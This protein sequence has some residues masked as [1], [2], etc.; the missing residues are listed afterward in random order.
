MF[1]RLS[2]FHQA[3]ERDRELGPVSFVASRVRQS[4]RPDPADAL[5]EAMEQGRCLVMLDGLDEVGDPDRQMGLGECLHE[6]IRRYPKNRYILTTRGVGGDDR[7][8]QDRGFTRLEI[9]RWSA[10]EVEQFLRNWSA[11]H[12]GHSPG[13][14]CRECSARSQDL[15]DEIGRLPQVR[16]IAANPLILTILASL[17]HANIGL[18]RKRRVDLYSKVVETFLVTWE[19]KKLGARPGE[20][21]HGLALE[22]REFEWF[23]AALALAMVRKGLTLAP[24]WWVTEL[25]QGYLQS[26]LGFG[27]EEAKQECDRVMRYLTERSGLLV[28]RGPDVFGYSHLTFQEYFASREI[29]QESQAD[30]S[31]DVASRLRDTIYN[32]RWR[33]TVRLVAAQLSPQQADGLLR[34]ILDDPDPIGRFLRRGQ[35]LALLCVGDGA[36]VRDRPLI[37][38]VCRDLLDSGSSKWLG[39]TMEAIDV[40]SQLRHT[41]FGEAAE[42]SAAEILASA[43]E[44]LS[45]EEWLTL[46]IYHEGTETDLTAADGGGNDKLAFQLHRR[47]VADEEVEFLHVN[48][49]LK[50][51]QPDTWYEQTLDYVADSTGTLWVKQALVAEIGRAVRTDD[52]AREALCALLCSDAE[53]PV[54]EVCALRLRSVAP[55]E[56]LALDALLRCFRGTGPEEVRGRCAAALEKVAADEQAIQEELRERLISTDSGPV[57]E[58]CIRA[59]GPALPGSEELRTAVLGVLSS[60]DEPEDVRVACAWSLQTALAENPEV[61]EA[62]AERLRDANSPKLGRVAAQVLA[63]ALAE[64]AVE[65]A[66]G[67]VEPIEQILTTL[68]H[69]CPHA[70]HALRRLV[71]ARETRVTLRMDRVIRENLKPYESRILSALIFGSVAHRR[72]SPASDIDLLVVGDVSLKEVSRPLDIAERTLGR[73]VNPVL[74]SADEFRHQYRSG[75]P[76]ILDIARKPK[77]FIKGSEDELRA[78]VAEQTAPAP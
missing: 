48:L 18:P 10:K 76:F 68:D 16:A 74:Y 44:S 21:L 7:P 15:L 66:P 78:M 39:I 11:L 50:R 36:P 9:S 27:S 56:S 23:L 2:D 38:G 22:A 3:R 54:R 64:E 70:L 63:N 55:D 13:K 73:P 6:F 24:R 41:R 43:R 75:N 1:I 45:K 32:P 71:D 42:S 26:H 30:G 25:L 40:L 5:E 4:G 12:H 58:G 17:A 72:Q 60:E 53:E 20:A 8:W 34:T 47:H 57:R 52:R 33:E 37:E 67:L 49:D 62:L 69:P 46:H 61:G 35:F 28:E 65:W 51:R 77:I 31:R 29:L 19:A 59:L 14:Q